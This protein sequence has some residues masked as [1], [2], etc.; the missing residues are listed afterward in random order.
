MYPLL[1]KGSEERKRQEAIKE[2]LDPAW[3][4]EGSVQPRQ[5]RRLLSCHLGMAGADAWSTGAD[6]GST[7]AEGSLRRRMESVCTMQSGDRG[8]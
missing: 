4:G 1:R 3:P 8:Q 2:R 6:A 5:D 7:S